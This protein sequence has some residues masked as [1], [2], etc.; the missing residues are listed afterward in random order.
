VTKDQAQPNLILRLAHELS[1]C[2]GAA[3]G[4]SVVNGLAVSTD[5]RGAYSSGDGQG[6][7]GQASQ[8]EPPVVDGLSAQLD[9]TETPH[10]T[11][12]RYLPLET[13]QG[14]TQAVMV[15][16]AEADVLGGV[17]AAQL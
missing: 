11:P 6:Q 2:E 3:G 8:I 12:H 4:C 17:G 15:A 7:A 9:L 13:G 14:S 5:K 10:E 16:A 1:F